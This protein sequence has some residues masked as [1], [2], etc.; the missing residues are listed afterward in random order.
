M[1][2]GAVTWAVLGLIALEPRSGYDIKRIVDRTIRHFWAASYGQIY[3]ELARLEE[4]GWITGADASR[5]ERSRRLFTVT[6]EGERALRGW[7]MGRETRIELRDESLLRLFFADVGP[8]ELGPGLLQAR[9]QGYEQM[10]A[11]LEALD[12]G[13][14]PDPPCVDLVYRWGLD[15]C[16]W[17]IEWCAE[18]ERRLRQAA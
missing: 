18:Q 16:K 2:A 3:P 17:G 9:R 7:L 13:T 11:H 14:G 4:L 12:D 6:A 1:E 15:Y 10:L 8:A 5:G